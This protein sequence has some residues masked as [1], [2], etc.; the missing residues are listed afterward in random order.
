[1]VTLLIYIFLIFELKLS[2]SMKQVITG[3]FFFTVIF[4]GNAVA[5]NYSITIN[6][7]PG[8]VELKIIKNWNIAMEGYEW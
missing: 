7:V 3:L 2:S 1:M 6:Y 4:I 8:D 5:K